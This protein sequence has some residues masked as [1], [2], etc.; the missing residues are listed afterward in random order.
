MSR[1]IRSILA[2]SALM[3]VLHATIIKKEPCSYIYADVS[4]VKPNL[5]RQSTEPL[6]ITSTFSIS[7]HAVTYIKMTSRYSRKSQIKSGGRVDWPLA[8]RY[9]F[10][11]GWLAWDYVVGPS[12]LPRWMGTSLWLLGNAHL[13]L[14]FLGEMYEQLENQP[15]GIAWMAL[16]AWNTLILRPLSFCVY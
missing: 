3:I 9:R 2:K 15:G 11:A 16:M 7:M 14:G 13:P 8:D 5:E 6:W 4:I 10:T 12:E 1:T